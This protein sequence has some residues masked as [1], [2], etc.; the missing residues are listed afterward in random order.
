MGAVT[1]AAI[2]SPPGGARRGV[3]R[4]SGPD[5]RRLLETAFSPSEGTWLPEKRSVVHGRFRDGRGEQPALL[6]W[7]PSPHSYTREDV[8]ELHLPGA[9]ALL[10]AA[11]ARLIE[12]LAEILIRHY[13]DECVQQRDTGADSESAP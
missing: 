7:M 12:H 1:I 8:A 4:L 5:A 13:L 11:L 9:P 10:D 2:S 3:I 6:L